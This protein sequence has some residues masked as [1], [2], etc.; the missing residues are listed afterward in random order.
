LDHAPAEIAS[1]L[2]GLLSSFLGSLFVVF[3]ALP[4]SAT[5]VG[6]WIS[7]ATGVSSKERS[8]RGT[9]TPAR[10]AEFHDL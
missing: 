10:T 6:Q 3:L 1:T 4:V 8:E 5:S 9:A 7:Q 2:D